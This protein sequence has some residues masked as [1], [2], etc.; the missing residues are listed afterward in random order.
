MVAVSE[1]RSIPQPVLKRLTRY[2]THLES[3]RAQGTR[4]AP[5]R[6]LAKTLGLT[7]STVRHDLSF[8]ALA[9]C[10][11]RGY[12]VENLIR[13]VS[14]LLGADAGWKMV[15]VGAGNL[16]LAFA[17]HDEFPG[18]RFTIHGIFDGDRGRVGQRVG[19]LTVQDMRAMPGVVRAERVDI[20]IIAVSARAAQQAADMLICSGVRGLLNLA[21]AHIVVPKRVRL[22]DA[23]LLS[24]MLEL[25]HAIGR[26]GD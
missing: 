12:G 4:W 7:S 20:G 13:S 23:R 1:G 14:R 22:V 15:V 8:L 6:V 25:A 19:S 2:L 5:S 9:S 26:V 21:P 18:R 24:G 11:R 3:L 17:T 16:G 10:S